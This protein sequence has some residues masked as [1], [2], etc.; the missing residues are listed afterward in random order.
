MTAC[1]ALKHR[2]NR[3]ICILFD[4]SAVQGN[5]PG[6][7]VIEEYI[8]SAEEEALI[9]AI[10][11]SSASQSGVNTA[12]A[13]TGR[14]SPRSNS[15]DRNHGADS[16]RFW[17]PQAGAVPWCHVVARRVQHYGYAFDYTSR[18]V[19]PNRPIGPLP[20]LVPLVRSSECYTHADSLCVSICDAWIKQQPSAAQFWIDWNAYTSPTPQAHLCMTMVDA[21]ELCR[22][23]LPH[24]SASSPIS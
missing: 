7:T 2:F 1:C 15:V 14:Y 12:S 3:W 16:Y 18:R 13:D 20:G 5:I 22:Q 8:T 23:T 11:G 17:P 6:L 24:I 10:E 9:I 19:D 4:C 21:P